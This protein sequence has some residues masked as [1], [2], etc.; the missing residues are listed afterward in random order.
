M[1]VSFDRVDCI[2]LELDITRMCFRIAHIKIALRQATSNLLQICSEGPSG[3]SFT[4]TGEKH[5]HI[6]AD[7][8]F[9]LTSRVSE[10]GPSLRPL[11]VT[12]WTAKAK[13]FESVLLNYKA[14]LEMFLEIVS[15]SDGS[16]EI[17][18]NLKEFKRGWKTMSYCLELCLVKNSLA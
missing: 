14:I 8:W 17:L 12:R 18:L 1:I 10:V 7:I 5:K 11:C 9:N 13:L 2:T 4:I 6:V 3:G 15:E 16:I